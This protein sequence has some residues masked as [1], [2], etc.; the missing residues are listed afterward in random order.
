MRVKMESQISKR[1]SSQ[2]SRPQAEKRINF[3]D[4][5]VLEH[6]RKIAECLTEDAFNNR[7]H[8]GDDLIPYALSDSLAMMGTIAWIGPAAQNA[9]RVYGVPASLLMSMH[10]TDY[11]WGEE[12]P[13]DPGDRFPGERHFLKE[14]KYLATSR[15]VRPALRLADSPVAYA[16][17]LDELGFMKD[18]EN[19]HKLRDVAAL[20]VDYSL[21]ECDF[22]YRREPIP[23]EVTIEHAA[24]M[25]SLPA[26]SVRSLVR[27]GTIDGGSP[28]E[29]LY[30][31][32][33]SYEQRQLLR[34]IECGQKPKRSVQSARAP[35]NN[36]HQL[37][38]FPALSSMP[39]AVESVQ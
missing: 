30:R 28:N 31:S 10:I 14:A 29:V 7:T 5:L 26:E 21:F 15:R 32:L 39:A 25:L 6:L 16:W 38:V 24:R 17:R 19:A 34:K 13:A 37:L 20:I 22:R 36:K 18:A 8:T 12:V 1:H 35:R 27:A 11:G 4:R 23:H 9:Q 33:K 3:T 2:R